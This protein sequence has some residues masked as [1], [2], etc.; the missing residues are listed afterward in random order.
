MDDG[1]RVRRIQR[2][3]DLDAQ[4]EHHLDL[5]RLASDPMP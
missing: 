5:H 2:V 4:I 1:L 3:G